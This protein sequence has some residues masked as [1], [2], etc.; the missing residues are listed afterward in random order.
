MINSAGKSSCLFVSV[1]CSILTFTKAYLRQRSEAT[2][3][4]YGSRAQR[5]AEKFSALAVKMTL[6]GECK[7]VRSLFS[8]SFSTKAGARRF[9][10]AEINFMSLNKLNETHDK[11]LI[12]YNSYKECHFRGLDS[13]E[14]EKLA[15][16]ESDHL[17]L[18]HLLKPSCFTSMTGN[19]RLAC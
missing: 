12:R 2:L 17:K 18:K 14:Q 3:W 11:I 8:F 10:Y 13:F 16:K 1:G 9:E 15:L 7:G 4:N 6:H 19:C 5:M